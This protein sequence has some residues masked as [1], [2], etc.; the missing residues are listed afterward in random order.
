MGDEGERGKEGSRE[1]KG[2]GEKVGTRERRESKKL[3]W[4]ETDKLTR[5]ALRQ[6][7]LAL[8]LRVL[9]IGPDLLEAGAAGGKLR[10]R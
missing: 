8:D 2:E 6:L 4:R 10:S 9:G 5:L 1:G 3:E 7:I